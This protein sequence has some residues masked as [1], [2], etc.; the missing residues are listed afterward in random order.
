MKKQKS[1][2]FSELELMGLIVVIWLC[3]LPFIGLVIAPFFGLKSALTAALV[4][5]IFLL[6]YCWGSCILQLIL[7]QSEKWQTEPSA[8]LETARI[9]AQIR[10]RK[11]H[12]EENDHA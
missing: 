2:F 6:L 3:S 8:D 5:L 1:E 12:V 7:K 10:T 11:H 4:L 9:T